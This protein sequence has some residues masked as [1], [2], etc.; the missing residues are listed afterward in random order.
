[1]KPKKQPNDPLKAARK[2]SREAEIG[3]YD[4][5]LPKHIVHQ[6][7]KNYNRKTVKARLKKG[8]F[9]FFGDLQCSSVRQ[10]FHKNAYICR[11]I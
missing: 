4:H 2:G 5:P 7:K 10:E 9:C 6:S 1:M 11:Y 3:M 8:E